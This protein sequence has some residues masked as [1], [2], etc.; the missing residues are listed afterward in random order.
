MHSFIIDITNIKPLFTK[1]K[2]KS[3][4]KEKKLQKTR[5]LNVIGN[6]IDFNGILTCQGLF[7]A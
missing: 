2:K 4:E 1:K 6:M 5:E 3:I 7:H